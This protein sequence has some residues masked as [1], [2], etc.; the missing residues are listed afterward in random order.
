MKL[1]FSTKLSTEV[2]WMYGFQCGEIGID[3]P[4]LD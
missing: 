2:A 4:M 1:L 3:Y